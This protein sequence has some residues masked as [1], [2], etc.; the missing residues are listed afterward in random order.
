MESNHFHDA[1]FSDV[2]YEWMNRAPW[3]ALSAAAHLVAILVL[4][5]IPWD[6]IRRDEPTVILAE[7]S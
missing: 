3:F 1:G 4:M 5:A 6:L 7:V 2:L